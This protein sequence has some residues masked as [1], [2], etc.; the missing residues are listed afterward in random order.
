MTPNTPPSE[1]MPTT[2]QPSSDLPDVAAGETASPGRRLLAYRDDGP[3]A[4]ALGRPA[5]GQLPPLPP[6]LVASI[7]CAVLL[8][9]RI[10]T[11]GGLALLAPAL[12]LLL[13]GG[14]GSAHTHAGRLDWAVPVIIRVI[15]YS[16]LAMVG[17]SHG[18]PKPLV[19]A[20]IGVLAFH[21]YDT[22]Y[23][24]RQGLWPPGWVFRAGLG[25]D[26]R[27]LLAALGALTHSTPVLYTVL[28]IYLG[29]LFTGEAIHTW[30]HISRHTG[31]I[32]D[33]ENDDDASAA[34]GRW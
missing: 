32:I 6:M 7:V 14:P 23:R 10:D 18:V 20:F 17:F 12:V 8:I 28:S 22:V 5:R 11:H 15:E 24:I 3:I 34:D 9:A 2:D 19:F 29:V 31:V 33:L 16:Y 4:C 26:G 27:M 13:L 25:W 21:H 1:T 30:R